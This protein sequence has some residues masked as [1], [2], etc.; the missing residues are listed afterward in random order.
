MRKKLFDLSDEIVVDSIVNI[1]EIQ[2]K[3]IAVI[4]ISLK[5]PLADNVDDFW[6]NLMQGVDCIRDFPEGRRRDVIN[7][8]QYVG[9]GGDNPRFYAAGYLEEIDKFDYGYFRLSPK[10]ASLMD[11]TQRLFLQT[12]WEAL[13]DAGYG[14]NKLAGSRTGV[15]VG[16]N[17][18]P[19][20][21]QLIWRLE[22]Q[23]AAIAT[24]GNLPSV[25]AGRLSFLM[26]FKGPSIIVDTACSSSLTAIHIACKAIR[27]GECDQAV[28]G[29]VKVIMLPVERGVKLGIESSDSRARTFDDSSDGTGEGEGVAA[30]L[31]KPLSKAVRDGDNIYAVIKGSAVNQDGSSIGLTAP[32]VVA[33]EDVIVRAWKDAGV[34]PETITYIE[35]HGTGTK[36][37][38]PIEIDGISRAFR[39]HTNKKQFCAVGSIKTNIG[40]IDCAAGIA[41]FIKAVLAVKHGAVP[42]SLHFMRPNRK[43]NFEDSPVYVN[44]KPAKWNSDA[45]PRRCG[46]SA[47]GLSGT[48][49]HL[50]LEEFKGQEKYE[51]IKDERACILALSAKSPEALTELL[52]RYKIYIRKNAGIPLEN[53]CYTS[54]TGRGHY[55]YRTAVVVSNCDELIDKLER[56]SKNRLC[57]VEEEAVY[58]GEHKIISVNGQVKSPIEI[59]EREK[60]QISEA[61]ENKIQELRTASGINRKVILNELC[62]LYIKGADLDWESLYRQEAIQK[63]RLPVYPFERKRCWLDMPDVQEQPLEKDSLYFNTHWIPAEV[64][65][66]KSTQMEKGCTLVFMDEKGIGKQIVRRLEQQ[67]I[68]VIEVGLGSRFEKTGENSYLISGGSEDYCRII[69]SIADKTFTRIIHLMSISVDKGIDDLKALEERQRRG[70]YSLFYL[71]KAL[72]N[73][74]LKQKIDIALVAECVNEVSGSEKEFSPE[75]SAMFGL[76]KVVSQENTQLVCRC[77]D[78]DE[79]S[80]AEAIIQELEAGYTAYQTAYRG[81]KRYI[82]ELKRANM[83]A[84]KDREV[85]IRQDGVYIITGG[86]GGIGLEIGKYLAKANKVK[87]ALIGRSQMPGREKWESILESE[88]DTKSCKIIKAV[89]EMEKD[90]AEVVYFSADITDFE[91]MEFILEALRAKYGRINGVIHSAGV[92]GD[93][94]I[95]R[96]DDNTF[97]NVLSPKI[98]GTWVLEKLTEQDKVDFFVM[99]SSLTS[100]LGGAGQGDYT[101]A[102]SYLDAFTAYMKRKGRK[103]LTINWSA[104]KE[105]GMAF[106]H[107]VND[108]KGVFKAMP[109]TQAIAAFDKVFRSNMTRVVI[110]ELNY[111]GIT[112]DALQYLPF[113]LSE[114]IKDDIKG[115]I[116][117]NSARDELKPKKQIKNARL[118]GKDGESYSETEKLVAGI[119]REVL[120]FEELDV[121]DNFFEIGG[122]SILI[123]K[124][125][126]LIEERLPG[127][128]TLVDLFA[129]PTIAR[130]SMHL[131]SLDEKHA[132]RGESMGNMCDEEIENDILRL[133]SEAKDGNLSIDEALE[134]YGL[135][136]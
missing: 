126:T 8:L 49:C 117:T 73:A 54:N 30:I 101:A 74:N 17:G 4:G 23:S 67:G 112:I 71:T 127:K 121:N 16:F 34:D 52:N 124:V 19:I 84:V 2:A 65:D 75:S 134:K 70:V 94:F 96:K 44:D 69:Q 13:E 128:V 57:N 26:D 122:D 111:D 136:G 53:I 89:R 56:L 91:S 85:S 79:E 78:V 72:L 81:G 15:Y 38:D 60:K 115:R 135:M 63:V 48:N 35:A 43:I 90:G 10:E 100:V 6:N 33:Q 46:V 76:G 104:W 118:K 25:I 32:N 83:E 28:A 24:A 116:K 51:G 37:G 130:L 87:L 108:E 61:A 98:Q 41:G 27:N 7:S 11:P 20:Y 14:G 110:G 106:D 123:S 5:M 29:G 9:M 3:D 133:I 86:A 68:E 95:I 55:N 132:A 129:H 58:Y 92:A 103:A 45:L 107:R 64:L 39:A 77:I 1:E 62:S 82:E 40:H 125:H 36:L 113:N 114:D 21:E 102:N 47:F 88:Q 42:P 80:G 105:T 120:G 22:P 119:W 59:T 12:A 50:V 97:K 18:W 93:G 66:K 109:T 131:C 99:F 31:L